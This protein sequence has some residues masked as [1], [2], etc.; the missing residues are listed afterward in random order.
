MIPV[1]FTFPSIIV[2]WGAI[3]ISS[4]DINLKTL[5]FWLK[6]PR[7]QPLKIGNKNLKFHSFQIHGEY[8]C[9][10]N[11]SKL[12]PSIRA[13]FIKNYTYQGASLVAQTVRICLQWRRLGFDPCV[14]KIPRAENGYPHQYSCLE[15]LMDKGVW[16][17]IVHG[18][19]KESDMTERLS[20]FLIFTRMSLII[21]SSCP[22]YVF[23]SNYVCD[24]YK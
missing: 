2:S 6:I 13:S 20:N 17:A 8:S 14:R 22:W 15:N 1:S 11:P 19:M 3:S 18:V 4:L 5:I 23:L 7:S 10:Q 9:Y 12:S 21:T 24:E 16:W